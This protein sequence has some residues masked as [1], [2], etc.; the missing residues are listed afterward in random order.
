MQ[1]D[2]EYGAVEPGRWAD[3]IITAENPLHD[4]HA[5]QKPLTV[6]KRGQFI[7]RGVLDTLLELAD[8]PAGFYI[9]MGMLLEDILTRW[10]TDLMA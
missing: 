6:V 4:I 1:L 2:H 3:F 9:G 5:L 8:C 7:D 10:W